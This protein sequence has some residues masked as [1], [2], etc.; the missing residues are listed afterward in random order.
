MKISTCQNKWEQS[1]AW[2]FSEL[3]FCKKQSYLGEAVPKEI[4]YSAQQRSFFHG[5]CSDIALFEM[6]EMCPWTWM[7]LLLI[8][9][10]LI[11]RSIWNLKSI[12]IQRKKPRLYSDKVSSITAVYKLNVISRPWKQNFTY[13][14]GRQKLEICVVLLLLGR[15]YKL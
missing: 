7:L 4:K 11:P 2:P 5:D 13:Y 10:I 9:W 8:N 14:W 6:T 1:N 15:L 3:L 12:W